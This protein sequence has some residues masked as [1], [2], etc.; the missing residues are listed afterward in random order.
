MKKYRVSLA[1]MSYIDYHVE[2]E[3]E[4]EA[5]EIAQERYE[6]G[7]PGLA[8]EDYY[9]VIEYDEAMEDDAV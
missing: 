1:F 3:S 5:L 6:Y 2:A 4:A 8:C 7:K 9:H